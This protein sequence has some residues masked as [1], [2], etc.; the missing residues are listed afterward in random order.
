MHDTLR[1]GALPVLAAL[2]CGESTPPGPGPTADTIAPEI[3]TL[4]PAPGDTGVSLL[5]RVEVTFS[6]PI[7]GATLGPASFSLWRG[8]A[9]VPV[10]Y[11]TDGLTAALQPDS[12]LD[13]LTSYTATLTSAVRDAAGNRVPRDT[14]WSFRTGGSYRARLF[15][16][17]HTL[18]GRSASRR[19]YQ[20]NQ[21]RP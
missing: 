6:E 10:S 21:A 8:V 17:N 9:P 16:T 13:S 12:L 3:V 20:R 2:A 15:T 5:G 11:L 14:T 1:L 18:A 19:M 7:N 4:S